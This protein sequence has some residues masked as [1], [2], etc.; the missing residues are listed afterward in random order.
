VDS[1]A[2][3]ILKQMIKQ[4]MVTKEVGGVF[5][6]MSDNANYVCFAPKKFRYNHTEIYVGDKVT[7]SMLSKNKGL[8]EQILPRRN[9]IT[10][11]QIANVDVV[12]VVIAPLPQPDLGLVDKI[13][14]NCFK[15]DV[16]PVLVINKTDLASDGFVQQ[17]CSCYS[18]VCD[19]VQVSAINNDGLEVLRPYFLNNVVCFAGQSAVGKTSI[20]NA[21][22]PSLNKQTGELSQK[23]QRGTHTTRHSQLYRCFDGYVV[24]TTGFSLLEI[25]DIHSKQLMLYYDD[26]VQLSRGCRYNMCTH[27]A[28]PDC[29]VKRAVEEGSFDKERYQR[30]CT[31]VAELATAE[32]NKY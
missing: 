7:F 15:N 22:I 18:K 8:I 23:T 5:T 29:A 6:V 11:P 1:Y 2:E 19:C 21:L 26:M 16:T 28:E 25:V 4:G 31:I 17:I 3:T 12:F 32:R 24:D 20:L 14:V 30:Y 27:T 13:L 9:L 10:R